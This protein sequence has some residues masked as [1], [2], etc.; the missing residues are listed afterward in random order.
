MNDEIMDEL[1][2]S[3]PQLTEDAIASIDQFEREAANRE[4]LH[5]SILDQ[6]QVEGQESSQQSSST[7]LQHHIRS[8]T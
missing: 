3:V 5:S 4:R 8:S 7:G 6:G 1:N 2:E